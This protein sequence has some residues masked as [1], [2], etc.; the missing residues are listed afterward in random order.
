LS[1]KY[2]DETPA[3]DTD[4][5]VQQFN[6][7]TANYPA[8]KATEFELLITGIT[9]IDNSVSPAVSTV[10]SNVIYDT[11]GRV[12]TSELL[13]DGTGVK[14]L[15]FSYNWDWSDTGTSFKPE[16][17]VTSN[18]NIATTYT[19]TT[20]DQG[21]LNTRVWMIEEVDG[22]D[23][24]GYT[25]TC[26][27]TTKSIA[28]NANG[29]V[30]QT[31]DKRGYITNFSRDGDNQLTTI[32][33][34]LQPST[35]N[36]IPESRKRTFTW[37]SSSPMRLKTSIQ[38]FESTGSAFA[39]VAYRKEDLTYDDG[40]ATDYNCDGDTGVNIWRICTRTLT[41]VEASE[42]RKWEYTYAMHSGT[43]IVEK[44]TV[45][46]PLT[47]TGDSVLYTF[48]ISSHLISITNEEGHVTTFAD[49]NEFGKPEATTNEQNIS[50]TDDNIKTALTYNARGEVNNS[51]P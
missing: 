1:V 28:Y 23:V 37:H 29:F 8:G 4:N 35:E 27:A 51:S 49:Y 15:T 10:Y 26:A 6:Y 19:F 47:G 22:E 13:D 31:T 41:D 44:I 34:P 39:S 9:E 16:T 50:D 21:I 45:D 33:T 42:S 25:T 12:S 18:T 24:D 14:T 5:F 38:Y 3:D 17:T 20:D 46:G 32:E 11:L 2:A 7:N 30:E 36:I 48:D 40:T 43:S